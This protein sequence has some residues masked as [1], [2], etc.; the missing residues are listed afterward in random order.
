VVQAIAV[1]FCI[2]IVVTFLFVDLAYKWV[3]PRIKF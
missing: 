2:T 3:D 1:M